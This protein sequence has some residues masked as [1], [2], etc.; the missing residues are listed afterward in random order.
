MCTLSRSLLLSYSS[1]I[2]FA[3]KWGHIVVLWC[4][5]CIRHNSYLNGQKAKSSHAKMDILFKLNKPISNP[6]VLEYHVSRTSGK[7]RW[8]TRVD[9]Q[10]SKSNLYNKYEYNQQYI[11]MGWRQIELKNNVKSWVWNWPQGWLPADIVL[12]CILFYSTNVG[13]LVI[14]KKFTKSVFDLTKG[15]FKLVKKMEDTA[16]FW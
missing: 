16:V 8:H 13:K 12:Y 6:L 3:L 1:P 5:I 9:L 4:F 7:I 15:I 2:L 10:S 14:K 11:K